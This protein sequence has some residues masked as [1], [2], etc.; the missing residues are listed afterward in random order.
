[1]KILVTGAS[2][3]VG[4]ELLPTLKA[5]GHEIYKLS[6]KAAKAADEIQWD[7]YN[8]FA[9]SEQ[10]KL[11]GFDAVIHLAGDNIAEGNW[12]EE[13]KKSIRD[14]RVTGTRTLVDALRKTENPPK[15]FISASATGFYGN[16]GDEILTEESAAGE[17]FLPEICQEWENEAN[18]AADFGARVVTPR[19]GVVL[20]KEGGALA[21]MLTPFKFGVGG[22]IGSGEQWMSWIALDDLIRVIH[23]VFEKENL[24]GA[25]NATASNPVTNE[26]FT[27]TLGKVVS[28]PTILPIP[29]FGIKFLFG[30]MG[31]RLLLEGARVLPEKLEN[32]GFEFKFPNLEDA[33]KY[34]LKN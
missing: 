7:A 1:M 5:K 3:L 25:V 12:T 23:F 22:T 14:S 21:K 15:I 11:E 32:E 13:K 34:I 9:E 4:G 2:G 8:G 20:A 28:R 30:E 18:K 33:L 24:R 31:E 27:N 19:I 6:R 29:A 10:A 26:E 17:G 16:R